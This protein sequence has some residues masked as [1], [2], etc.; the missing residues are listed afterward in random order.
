[1]FLTTRTL[2]PTSKL[3]T[4]LAAVIVIEKQDKRHG[5]RKCEFKVL[6]RHAEFDEM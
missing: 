6:R 2:V 5:A 4:S 1:M 3:R